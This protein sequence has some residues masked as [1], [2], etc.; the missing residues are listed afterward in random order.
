MG[1]M[2]L[3]TGQVKG[4]INAMADKKTILAI[5]DL[6]TQRAIY[7]AILGHQYDL[8]TCKSAVEALELLKN[9]QV[10]AIITDIDMPE[11]TGFEFLREKKKR[12]SIR[13]IPLIV[14][15][16]HG[17]ISRAAKYGADDFIPKPVNPSDLQKRIK[18]L[19]EGG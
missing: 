19:L 7:G 18:K 17:D 15:S 10:D 11:M 12:A 3:P 4:R 14:V 2:Y 13:Q 9:T 5:D 8:Q 1:E 6:A 16:G